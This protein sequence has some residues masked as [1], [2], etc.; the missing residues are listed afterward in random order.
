[1]DALVVSTLINPT[2]LAG[3][4]M[5]VISL[6]TG[7]LGALHDKKIKCCLGVLWFVSV[8][9]LVY[10]ASRGNWVALAVSLFCYCIFFKRKALWLYFGGML[11]GF[12]L[13]GNAIWQR[14]ISVFGS[15]DTSIALRFA[16]LEG[17][18]FILK[19]HPHGVGWYGFQFIYPEYVFYLNNPNVI[20]IG[21]AHV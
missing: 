5:L 1:M 8:W 9:C 21:R 11:M 4:L 15:Q 2:I 20:K 17:T 10:T 7:L 18:L 13:A 14:L 16:Y 6:A 12:V 3:Y 19:G